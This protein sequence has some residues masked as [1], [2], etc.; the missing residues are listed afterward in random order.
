M[1]DPK[2]DNRTKTPKVERLKLQRET[3]KEMLSARTNI[4]TGMVRPVTGGPECE[5]CANCLTDPRP[6]RE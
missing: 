4:K 1:S 3:L 6:T 5:G 2:S